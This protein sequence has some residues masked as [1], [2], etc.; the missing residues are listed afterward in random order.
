LSRP[1]LATT[2]P[3]RSS[4]PDLAGLLVKLKE[5]GPSR[6]VPVSFAFRLFPLPSS[7]FP[8]SLDPDKRQCVVRVHRD[9]QLL[10]TGVVAHRRRTGNIAGDELGGSAR[11]DARNSAV[12]DTAHVLRSVAQD[13]Q[14]V[15]AG[16]HRVLGLQH[17]TR[18]RECDYGAVSDVD[19]DDIPLLIDGDAVGLTKRR[20]L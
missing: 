15:V 16:L 7:L 9:H 18:R 12:D 20:A 14:T 4:A 13:D 8:Q 10:R 1:R 17:L 5:T 2:R 11:T 3:V 6:D 19:D